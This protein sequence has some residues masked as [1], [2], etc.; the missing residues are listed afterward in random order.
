MEYNEIKLKMLKENGALEEEKVKIL[1]QGKRMQAR[2]QQI[3]VAQATLNIRLKFLEELE[4]PG[5]AK[6]C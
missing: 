2:V 3:N 4:A 1:E 5:E 6:E